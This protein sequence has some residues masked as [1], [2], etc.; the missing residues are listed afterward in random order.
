MDATPRRFVRRTTL[1]EDEYRKNFR[2][3]DRDAIELLKSAEARR[4]TR[5]M[6]TL[7]LALID[8]PPEFWE[9]EGVLRFAG[10]EG[11]GGGTLTAW[12][13]LVALLDC[14]NTTA[15]KA[16]D[17][18]HERGVI[19]YYAGK[20]GAGIRIFIN[21]AAASIGSRGRQKNLRLVP[22][23]AT[24]PRTPDAGTPFSDSF[25]DPENLDSGNDPRAPENGADTG[26]VGKTASATT[27]LPTPGACAHLPRAEGQVEAAVRSPGSVSVEEIIERLKNELAPCVRDAAARAAAQEMVHT[28]EW[29]AAHALPKAIRI[30]Q[31][32]AYDVLRAHGVVTEPRGGRKNVGLEVGRHAPA[33]PRAET[34]TEDDVAMLAQSCVALFETQGQPVERTLAEMGVEGGGFLLPEDVPRVRARVE[35][36]LRG[37][38]EGRSA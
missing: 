28:R 9:R 20:N 15:K 3:I 16:L 34:L 33:S 19:G 11:E 29:F 10:G 1:G 2:Q 6:G 14:G 26:P 12:Q 21:R 7:Y 22:T 38:K 37:A 35:T 24:A 36:L 27:R 31:R 5:L 32:S 23:P 4:V 18:M 25:A 30:S 17:W 8:A 13:Q